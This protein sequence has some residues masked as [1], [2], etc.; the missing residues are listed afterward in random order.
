MVGFDKN[1]N[2]R[3]DQECNFSR[4]AESGLNQKYIFFQGI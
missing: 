2:P 1:L 4:F 3:E